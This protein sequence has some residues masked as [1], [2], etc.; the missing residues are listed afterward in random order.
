MLDY[1]LTRL[2]CLMLID[3]IFID[4]NKASFGSDQLIKLSHLVPG[5]IVNRKLQE[6]KIISSNLINYLRLYHNQMEEK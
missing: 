1:T 4:K 6:S 3:S 5:E 2:A